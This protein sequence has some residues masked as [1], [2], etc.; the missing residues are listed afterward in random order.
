MGL[1]KYTIKQEW[2]LVWWANWRRHCYDLCWMVDS[3]WLLRQFLPARPAAPP[4]RR[5]AWGGYAASHL[6]VFL[7]FVLF[8][9]YLSARVF[10]AV[11]LINITYR[12]VDLSPATP[13][14]RPRGRCRRTRWWRRGRRRGAAPCRRGG[15][16]TRPSPQPPPRHSPQQC[17]DPAKHISMRHKSEDFSLPAKMTII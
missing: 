15:P 11:Y 3:A 4:G 12:A 14:W 7:L 6:F 13:C 16:H 8:T 2:V 1:F 10:L 9:Y 17:W 5:T